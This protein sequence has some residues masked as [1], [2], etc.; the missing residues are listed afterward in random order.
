WII[1]GGLSGACK[2][3]DKQAVV[4]AQVMKLVRAHESTLGLI[5]QFEAQFE[6]WNSARESAPVLTGTSC[7]A[8]KDDLERIRAVDFVRSDGSGKVEEVLFADQFD[9]G[10]ELR[11]L[12]GWDPEH[13]VR[14]SPQYQKGVH[15][16]LERHP[17]QKQTT[18]DPAPL[19]LLSF[20]DVTDSYELRLSL[21]Q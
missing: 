21:R 8:R 18:R 14:L 15:A 1:L 10:Q 19:L 7:W 3:Q 16:F 4:S 13:P 17:F 6:I 12:K 5:H 2:G 11:V 9:D 20:R